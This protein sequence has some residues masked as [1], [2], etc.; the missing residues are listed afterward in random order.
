MQKQSDRDGCIMHHAWLVG[1]G[2]RI[3]CG[4]HIL[5]YFGFYVA[6]DT[7]NGVV[8]CV[9]VYCLVKTELKMTTLLD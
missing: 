8:W 6:V 2:L 7:A 1:F 9:T 5:R 3:Y 4:Y